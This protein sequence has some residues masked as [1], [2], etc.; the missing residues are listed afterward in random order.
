MSA[1]ATAEPDRY[2]PF[3]H[4]KDNGRSEEPIAAA[5]RKAPEA[6]AP[7]VFRGPDQDDVPARKTAPSTD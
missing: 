3:A 7:L 5:K 4:A 6:V 1:S 2:D